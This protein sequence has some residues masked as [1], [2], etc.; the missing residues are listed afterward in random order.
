M[1]E[2]LVALPQP[3]DFALSVA[4]YRVYGMDRATVW[5]E[6]GIHRVFGG[7]EVRIEAAPGGVDVR[8]HAAAIEAEVLQ[9]LGLPFDLGGFSVWAA[10]DETLAPLVAALA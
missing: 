7:E 4:R 5:H 10:G 2:V 6:G 9:F 3:Y 1:S 8:P